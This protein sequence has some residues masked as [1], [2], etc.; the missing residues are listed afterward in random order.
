M[1]EKMFWLFRTYPGND[2]PDIGSICLVSES[3][4]DQH[5]E[6]NLGHWEAKLA[7]DGE[8]SEQAEKRLTYVREFDGKTWFR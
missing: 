6:Y 1:E 8:T 2:R 3:W 4:I 7:L 5:P